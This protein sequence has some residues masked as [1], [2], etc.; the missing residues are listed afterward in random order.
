MTKKRF[1]R[2]GIV[3]FAGAVFLGIGAFW[4]A[5][6]SIDGELFPRNAKV[7]DLTG[8]ELSAGQ[9]QDICELFP[10]AQVLWSIPF[11]GSRYP[12]DTE[13]ITVTSLTEAEAQSLD[14]L[15][16]LKLVDGMQCTDL[17]ALLYLQ[18]RRPDCQVLYQVPVGGTSCGNLS[19][20]LTVTDA[21]A[22]ELE[23]ALPLLPQLRSLT[24]EGALPEPEVLLQLKAAFP[25]VEMNYTLDIWGQ[26]LSS[27]VQVIDLTAVPVTQQ[28]LVR[29]LP[30]FPD[31]KE[32]DLTDTNLTDGELKSLAS[33][34]PDIFFLCTMDFAGQSFSTGCAEIDISGCRTTVEET[35]ESLPFFPNLRKLIMSGCGI[36]DEAMDAMNRRHPEVSIVWTVKIGAISVRTDDTVFFPAGVNKNSLPDNEELKKLRYCTEMIAIDIGHSRASEC[37]WLEY[38]PHLK[39]LILADTKITDLTP[40]SNLKELLYLELFKLDLHDYSP[41]LGC[42][43]LQDL[44]ISSTYA[45]PE[46]LS[47]MTWLH[48]LYWNHGADDPAIRDA[49]LKLEEQLPDTNVVVITKEVR[50]NIGELWRYLPNYYVFRNLIGGSFLNQASTYKYWGYE[51]AVKILSCDKDDACFAGD[52]LAEIVRYRIDNGLPIVGI[53]NIGSE[54]AEILYQ[55]LCDSRP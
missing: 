20:E 38:M 40:L 22:A 44:N 45:D 42:T 28:E 12:M 50:R 30:L 16:N 7:Y 31:V 39:Y 18:Q 26:R 1:I 25:S 23:A 33:Q 51:D 52:V 29:L 14:L 41:L 32:L 54:K 3:G 6:V 34:F 49:V 53:K 27:D 21:N 19:Q 11:Q 24:L 15:P 37:G 4:V 36:D 17:S 9:Y 10:D 46:P 48:T 55:T 47:K 5:N 8:H 43:A 2:A 13:S 35:E